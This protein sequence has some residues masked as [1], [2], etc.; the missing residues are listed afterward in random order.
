MNYKL[1]IHFFLKNF[2]LRIDKFGLL[3]NFIKKLS[4]ILSDVS[5]N[6]SFDRRFNGENNLIKVLKENQID[7]KV[8]FDVGANKGYWSK[9][10]FN[11]FPQTSFYL[12]EITPNKLKIL[13]KIKFKNF[14]I[15]DFGLSN[16]NKHDYFFSYPSLDGEDSF[17]NI[18]PEVKFKKIKCKFMKGDQFCIKN[19]IRKIDFAKFDIEGMEYEALLGLEKMIQKQKIR[20]IQFEY[21]IAN[22]ISKYMLKDIYNF[23]SKNNYV[24]GKLTNKGVIFIENFKNEMNNFNSGPNFVACLK[25]DKDLII[26]LSNF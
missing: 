18:R 13:K 14:Q 9:Y 15:N 5:N 26:N 19:K 22:S 24:I 11:F 12:F 25:S 3:P 1:K 2:F 6:Y 23:F 16:S 7:M 10:F 8:V 20:L 17:F 21:T 4:L